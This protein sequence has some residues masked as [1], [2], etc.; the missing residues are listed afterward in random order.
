M[1]IPIPH[2]A[3]LPKNRKR[4][5]KGLIN[6]LENEWLM[7]ES[8]TNKVK[9]MQLAQMVLQIAERNAV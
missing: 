4:V 3:L 9:E 7:K 6:T 1:G 8:I 2:T 5:T